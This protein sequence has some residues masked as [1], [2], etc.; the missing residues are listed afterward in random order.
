M[1]FHKV[2]IFI[3]SYF[4]VSFY[5]ENKEKCLTLHPEFNTQTRSARHNSSF[6]GVHAVAFHCKNKTDKSFNKQHLKPFFNGRKKSIGR[7]ETSLSK[8]T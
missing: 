5:C 1:K 8:R 6:L 4:F 3:I 7:P 2:S